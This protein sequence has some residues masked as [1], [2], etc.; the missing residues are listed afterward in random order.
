MMIGGDRKNVCENM[1]KIICVFFCVCG[2]DGR[3]DRI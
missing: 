2:A 3:D 1:F